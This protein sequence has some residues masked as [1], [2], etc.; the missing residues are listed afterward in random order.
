MAEGFNAPAPVCGLTYI[1]AELLGVMPD[2]P[3]QAYRY[4]PPAVAPVAVAVTTPSIIRGSRVPVV[5]VAALSNDT[6][7]VCPEFE[8][9]EIDRYTTPVGVPI[10]PEMGQEI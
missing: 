6:G 7:Q 1:C 3:V 9:S 2:G 4:R 10:Y 5:N 8:P